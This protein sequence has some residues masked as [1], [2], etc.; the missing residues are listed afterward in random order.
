VVELDASGRNGRPITADL[1]TQRTP[2]Q[3]SGSILAR[4]VTRKTGDGCGES[5]EEDIRQKNKG[6]EDESQ[7]YCIDSNGNGTEG[8]MRFDLHRL[9]AAENHCDSVIYFSVPHFSVAGF[10]EFRI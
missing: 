2:L 8:A 1:S 9:T 4:Q 5:R 6:Q 7:V 3:S 10:S